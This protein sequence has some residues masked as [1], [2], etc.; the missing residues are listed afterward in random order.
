MTILDTAIAVF[1]GVAVKDVLEQG[2]YELKYR[3]RKRFQPNK[4][5]FLIDRINKAEEETE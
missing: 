1:I 5:Q 4:Y 3:L 2:Y